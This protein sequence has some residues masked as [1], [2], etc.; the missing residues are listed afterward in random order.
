MPFD[1]ITVKAYL[2]QQGTLDSVG[3]IEYL[4]K[5]AS[6]G[7]TVVNTEHYGRI[8]FDNARRRDLIHLGQDIIDDAYTEDL[9][10][11]VNT[12]IESAEQKLFNL[13]STGQSSDLPWVSP[14]PCSMLPIYQISRQ[15]TR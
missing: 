12:Q 11:T 9:D 3:G 4:T 8:I 1:V 5:L 6:A 15:M 2:E 7:T 10:K 14:L 13:A